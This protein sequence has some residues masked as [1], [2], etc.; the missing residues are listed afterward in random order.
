MVREVLPPLPALPLQANEITVPLLE[1]LLAVVLCPLFGRGRVRIGVGKAGSHAGA[2]GLSGKGGVRDLREGGVDG[3][4]VFGGGTRRKSRRQR[5][6]ARV[7]AVTRVCV[8]AA[9]KA[10]RNVRGL[11][12][13]RRGGGR[14]CGGLRGQGGALGVVGSPRVGGLRG[15]FLGGDAFAPCGRGAERRLGGNGTGSFA[16]GAAS[17]VDVGSASREV[18]AEK[19]QVG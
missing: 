6:S 8:F 16:L 7:E 10:R 11:L 9:C 4:R 15:F 14:G 17:C 13:A 3:L 5:L 12:P 19:V 1:K 2:D 18:A